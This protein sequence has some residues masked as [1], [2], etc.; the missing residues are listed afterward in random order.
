V[1][2]QL[3]PPGDSD[4]T[5][6]PRVTDPSSRASRPPSFGAPDDRRYIPV[7]ALC[8]PRLDEDGR[9]FREVWK[10]RDISTE[11]DVVVKL[12]PTH[13]R[14]DLI[15]QVERIGAA[16]AADIPGIA[17]LLDHQI[18]DAGTSRERL[19][20]ISQF[21]PGVSLDEV[22]RAGL[23][24][25][26]TLAI[27]TSLVECLSSVHA[28]GI[29]HGDVKPTN[30]IV[31]ASDQKPVLIDA[32]S[33]RLAGQPLLASSRLW[34][35]P[36]AAGKAPIA[37]QAY[38][39]WSLGL[40]LATLCG[41]SPADDDLPEQRAI[42]ARAVVQEGAQHSRIATRLVEVISGLLL[43]VAQRRDS[44]SAVAILTQSRI[45]SPRRKRIAITAV[46]AGVAVVVGGVAYAQ[47]GRGTS[48]SVAS[49]PR[50]V[51]FD[52]VVFGKAGLRE[53]P[54]PAALSTELRLGCHRLGCNVRG[55]ERHS[56]GTL[57]P[58]VCVATGPL[59]TNGSLSDPSDDHNPNLVASALWYGVS[60]GKGNSARHLRYISEVWVSP[61]Q[62]GGLGLPPCERAN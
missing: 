5:R 25:E 60:D 14:G 55:T 12:V 54:T 36:E 23:S 41:F 58:P 33:A 49:A 13:G 8:E 48:N 56:G 39:C 29:V 17:V 35:P 2:G 19:A 11:R 43:P 10:Y 52:K 16:L 57:P 31:R 4:R 9:V 24:P 26:Q 46:A 27:A 18:V 62:R 59:V 37:T 42:R 15:A 3:D 61:H 47:H 32:G 34:E 50:L 28:A 53:D 21:I 51:I 1:T 30:V 38:D 22:T 6:P 45:S 40:V 7:A 44:A 20:L